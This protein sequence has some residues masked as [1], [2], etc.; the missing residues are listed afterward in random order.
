[1]K[2]PSP[3]P[4]R[5][6]DIG[7]FEIV[8]RDGIARI[9]KFHTKHGIITT[10]ALLP[11]INPNIR[12]IEPKEMW[13]S[14]GVECLITNSY[15]IRKSE[16]LTEIAVKEGVHSLLDFPGV[17]MTDSGTFQS[18]V[19]GDIEVEPVE[20]IEF[21]KKIGV[22]IC[23]MLDVFGKP[24]LNYEESKKI[25]EETVSRSEISVNAAQETM[26]NG[27]IQGGLFQDLRHLSAIKMSEF[28]FTIHPIG[29]IVPLMEKQKYLDLIKII[30][31]C[32]QAIP[33]SRPVHLFGCGHPH[34]FG[35][36]V[37]MG[38]DLF[39]SAAYALFAKDDR[40]IMPWGT[41]KLANISEWPIASKA[42]SDLNPK[43]VKSLPKKERTTLLAKFNL[44]ISLKEMA[45]VREAVRN[46]KIWEYVERKSA[47]H[48]ALEMAV[49]Y[50][51]DSGNESEFMTWV[52]K[53]TKLQRNKGIL[54][55]Q[56]IK[57][58]P[59]IKAINY[60]ISEHI[61]LPNKDA[62][63]NVVEQEEWNLIVIHGVQG[64]WRIRCKELIYELYSKFERIQ[65][66]LQTPVGIIPYSLEDVNPFSQIN[67][68]EH[69]WNYNEDDLERE[70][71][72][73]TLIS[74][75]SE[76]EKAI[77][78]IKKSGLKE[79][80]KT[81]KFDKLEEYLDKNSIISKTALFSKLKYSEAEKWLSNTTF[82]KGGTGRIR[83]VFD[84]KGTHILSPR[85]EDGGL[86]L[87]INGAKK[88]L[89]FWKDG[90]CEI[91]IIKIDEG[92]IPFVS[93]GRNVMHGFIN[94]ASKNLTPGSPCIIL[95]EENNLIASGIS[96]CTFSEAMELK[97]GVAIKVKNGIE[98]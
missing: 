39:D 48:P 76:K 72:S 83:N 92:A 64:P 27:P 66:L 87:T 75:N 3:K 60:E 97:K 47:E 26:I 95:D 2:H 49:N 45:R 59:Y 78:E 50:L 33:P 80:E 94:Y 24:N 63:G 84:Q 89:E 73:L 14:F 35:I 56:K 81:L 28:E 4:C 22:D 71:N 82:L 91:P 25:V 86:S 21:Q 98:K 7:K 19:Y 85:L 12:T 10:P 13:D 43:E 61:K 42:L 44:E 58:H 18:Y 74:G 37:A 96:C 65:I 30:S 88:L 55:S 36:A 57:S 52:Q 46:G 62:F 69:I 77:E 6:N 31:S 40:M 41:E 8:S 15:I 54:W 38:V 11:V 34:L 29:G 79:S 70:Y 23:T 20:I 1:M 68:P 93:K 9:G 5:E 51:L 53:S 17:I 32:R 16:N 90:S 67:G